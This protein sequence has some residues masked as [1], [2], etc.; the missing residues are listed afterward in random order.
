MESMFDVV[1]IGGGA[2]G[3]MCAAVAGQ[4]GEQ[5]RASRPDQPTAPVKCGKTLVV[6]SSIER[7][8]VRLSRIS[9]EVNSHR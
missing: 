7:I 1:V 2:A 3:L 8:T 6:I 4:R 9:L 5:L